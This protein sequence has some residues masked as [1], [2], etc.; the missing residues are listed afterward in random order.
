MHTPIA[1][2]Y[3]YINRTLKS[4]NFFNSQSD[5]NCVCVYEVFRVEDTVPLFINDHLKRLKNSANIANLDLWKSNSQIKQIVKTLIAANN[6]EIGNI[7]L[8]FRMKPNGDR[9]FLAFLL[10]VHYPETKQYT[11]GVVACFQEAERQNPTAKIFNAEVRGEANNIIEKEHVYETVLVNH[12]N[13]ITE[14]SRSNLFFIKDG[15]FITAP[16]EM[17][18]PGVIRQKLIEI[19][20]NKGWGIKFEAINLEN[21]AKM[22]A[23]FITGTSPRVLPIKAI[24]AQKLNA[25]HPLIKE[26]SAE[27]NILIKQYKEEKVVN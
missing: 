11:E 17:V 14:G 12:H 25:N 13:Q 1:G 19:I 23:A 15:I 16:D 27:L 4:I 2:Q 18:L 26:I 22:E 24:D 20:I 6:L 8:E 10:P 5:D 9:E 3:F 7:K 21:V